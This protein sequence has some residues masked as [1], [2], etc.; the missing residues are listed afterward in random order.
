MRQNPPTLSEIARACACGKA[1]VSRA[2]NRH[3]HVSPG[4]RRTILD[5]AQRLG[6][7][8][9]PFLSALTARRWRS[10]DRAAHGVIA[11]LSTRNLFS[12]PAIHDACKQA[13]THRGYMFRPIAFSEHA[14]PAILQEQLER[15]GVCG[16]LLT[17]MVDAKK[18]AILPSFPTVV[19][20]HDL[21][22]LD[23][24]RVAYDIQDALSRCMRVALAQGGGRIG[25]THLAYEGSGTLRA[26][27]RACLLARAELIEAGVHCPQPFSGTDARSLGEWMSDEGL[28]TIIADNPVIHSR[29]AERRPRRYRPLLYSG[30]PSDYRAI[31]GV[32]RRAIDLLQPAI[33]LLHERLSGSGAEDVPTPLFLVP[34]HWHRGSGATMLNDA[35]RPL[36]GT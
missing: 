9:D 13:C 3:A 2:L 19:I 33:Q 16:I 29:L 32:R 26:F 15:Q 20:D 21:P 17:S 28:D 5:T 14:S 30:P 31:P 8:P 22:G 25:L 12:I 36:L 4:L 7:R 35:S 6:W 23:C 27:H 24:P 18:P 10:A 1:T 34:G 11:G